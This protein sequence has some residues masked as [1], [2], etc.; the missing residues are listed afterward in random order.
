M[1]VLVTGHKGFIGTILVPM[2]V[3]RGYDVAGLDSDLYRNCTYGEPPIKVAETIKDVRDV[4]ESDVEGF[5]AI[6]HLAA[7][8]NDLLGNINPELTME[9]NYAASVRLAELAKAVGVP[10]FLFSSSCSMY[11]AGGDDFLDEKAHFN[12]VTPYAES[13]VM[14][15]RDISKLADDHFTPVFLR[16]ATAYGVS[17]RMRFD[18]V[19]NNLVAW[20][21]TTGNI[22]MKSDGTPWRPIVHIEDIS[23]AFI[24][25]L[26]APKH[27][28][29]NQSF[30][31]GLNA[32][33][34]RIRELADFVKETIPGCEIEYADGAGPDKRCYRVDF[35]KYASTFP[36]SSLQ[37][38]ARRGAQQ[39]YESYQKYGLEKGEYEGVRYK[40]IL[41]IMYLLEN[42]F[43]DNTLRWMN[44]KS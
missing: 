3:D 29:H 43:I 7:L 44:G 13:K 19:L 9:I 16:N 11:G 34:Y 12:P 2:L 39:I 31:I 32:E 33:N 10:K 26:E 23:R 5:D 22:L 1:R 36:E 25:M 35:S 27:L 40:R 42:Q 38:N 17:P 37:W 41:H 4:D 6:I 20:A 15:E 21:Y 24:A 14:S 18:L 30:N 28:V 8:S